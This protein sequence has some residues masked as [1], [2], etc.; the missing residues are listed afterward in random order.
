MVS[1]KRFMV[2]KSSSTPNE[3]E[4]DSRDGMGHA[5]MLDP[6]G[7]GG[8]ALDDGDVVGESLSGDV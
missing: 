4:E 6:L 3:V 8:A 1:L 2:V 7:I 5:E